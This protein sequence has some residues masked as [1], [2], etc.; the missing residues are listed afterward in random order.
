[1]PLASLDRTPPP[2]FGQGP[3][4]FTKLAFYSALALFFM[5]VDV[6]FGWMHPLRVVLSVGLNV[7]QRVLLIPVN[8][9]NNAGDYFSGVSRALASEAHARQQ[10]IKLSE[11]AARAEILQLENARLRSLLEL[12]P[13]LYVRS[14]A[15]EVLY[16]SAD[17]FSRKVVIDQGSLKGVA[18][19]S[20]V[21]NEV[22]VLGQITRVY[23]LNS[24]VTLLTDKDA[25]IPVLNVRTQIRGVANGV[26]GA[27]GAPGGLELRFASNNADIQVGDQL[28]T[29]GVDGIYPDGLA[30]AK[31]LHVERTVDS[32]F[33]KVLLAP[34]AVSDSVRHVLV[35]QPLNLQLPLQVQS[36]SAPVSAPAKSPVK[37][38]NPTKK[39]PTP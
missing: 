26:A 30:V 24:E 2:F 10:Q 4:A 33:A 18:L 3:S 29:S 12:R 39:E 34:L 37:K 38:A 5:V 8:T 32:G 28:T 15:A 25:A 36:G 21:I 22:G 13:A 35:L 20:P 1:M 9:A 27:V 19:G 11:K 23:P 14:Q 31:V 6:K 17:P 16:E 7:V